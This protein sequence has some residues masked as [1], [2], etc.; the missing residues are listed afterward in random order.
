[1]MSK[2]FP[3]I[4][5][6]LRN[7]DWKLSI[8]QIIPHWYLIQTWSAKAFK[9]AVV[10]PASSSL[11][12]WSLKITLTNPADLALL[13][14]TKPC[15][16]ISDPCFLQSYCLFWNW[17]I[18]NLAD[19]L[20]DIFWGKIDELYINNLKTIFN[21]GFSNKVTC[22][23]LL[24]R[25]KNTENIP[26]KV[27]SLENRQYL[28]HYWLDKGFL[29]VPF[30]SGIAIFVFR[31]TLNN[32]VTV[33]GSAVQIDTPYTFVNSAEDPLDPKHFITRIHGSGG[34][35]PGSYSW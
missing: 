32:A 26:I 4:A 31:V 33:L 9:G 28:P 6:L 11:H 5:L 22:A 24:W 1:M 29:R 35:I 8:F 15:S 12:W 7:P 10:N 20:S 34:F 18:K 27:L 2:C 23:F 19:F 17:T 3:A 13:F 21:C 16:L 14:E 30:K 25:K